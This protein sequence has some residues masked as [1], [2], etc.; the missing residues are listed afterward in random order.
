MVVVSGDPRHSSA[1][2]MA[3]KRFIAAARA[4]GAPCAICYQAIDY[5]GG[6]RVPYGPSLDHLYPIATHPHL[7]LVETYWRVTH[8]RCN[9]SR[10]AAFGN[11]R[12]QAG[13]GRRPR[14]PSGPDLVIDDW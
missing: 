13:R 11:A 2:V 12:R 9:L 6:G 5:L 8:L 7:A 4:R 10:G 14:G 3:R 1:Y